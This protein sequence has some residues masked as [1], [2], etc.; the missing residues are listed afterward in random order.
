MNNKNVVKSVIKAL[1]LFEELLKQSEPISI[2]SLSNQTGM[3][4]STVYRL[5]NTM[6][7]K[8]YVKQN[9]NDLYCLGHYA[10]E[11][12]D[13]VHNSFDFKKYIHPFLDKLV[14]ESN[15][16]SFFSILI[17]NKVVYLDQVE[18]NNFLRTSINKKSKT[19]A[20][21]TSAGK[22]MLSYL[23][24]KSLYNYL[25][26]TDLIKYSQKTITDPSILKEEL[27]KTKK[28]GYAIEIGEFEKGLLSVAAPILGKRNKLL[29]A[30]C[31]SGP[32]H[33]VDNLDLNQKIIPLIKNTAKDISAQ[34]QD[35]YHFNHLAVK[36]H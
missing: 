18:S 26:N 36:Q 30:I 11:I 32:C 31:I 8:G 34:L 4:I 35:S 17:D 33:R 7:N 9:E 20:Y 2:S 23:N 12:A 16:T 3:N 14:E 1:N 5:L 22:I 25:E 29:G 13:M 28:Q 6:M 10:Y 24:E 27:K 15:E 21:C 19:A